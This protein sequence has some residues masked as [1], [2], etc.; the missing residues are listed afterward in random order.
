M[1]ILGSLESPVARSCIERNVSVA[2]VD[3]VANDNATVGYSERLG[4]MPRRTMAQSHEDRKRNGFTYASPSSSD[5]SCLDRRFVFLAAPFLASFAGGG[6]SD[7]SLLS[8]MEPSSPES[9]PARSRRSSSM[10]AILDP[11]VRAAFYEQDSVSRRSS[12][13]T[14]QRRE[15]ACRVVCRRGVFN[16][17]RLWQWNFGRGDSG[18]G[19]QCRW[20]V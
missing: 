11:C 4:W 18:Q 9:P 13:S 5:S 7:R 2:D 3:R 1:P 14:S 16:E 6:D 20:S 10:S 8:L 15:L 17:L 19:N 12:R